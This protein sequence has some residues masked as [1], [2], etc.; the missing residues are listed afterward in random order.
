MGPETRP[1]A[2]ARSLAGKVLRTSPMC[3]IG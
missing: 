1:L 3:A 2:H